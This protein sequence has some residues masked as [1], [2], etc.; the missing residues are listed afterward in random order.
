MQC[1]QPW[2]STY[3]RSRKAKAVSQVGTQGRHRETAAEHAKHSGSVLVAEAVGTQGIQ[4]VSHS[5]LISSSCSPLAAQPRGS[6]SADG[7]SRSWHR[8]IWTANLW[9]MEAVEHTRQRQCLSR[10]GGGTHKAKAVAWLRT[11][12]RPR[13]PAAAA[14]GHAARPS[15]FCRPSPRQRPPP[16]PSPPLPPPPRPA[17]PPPSPQP[18]SSRCDQP[19]WY[20][21]AAI[22]NR[23]TTRA[24]DSAFENDAPGCVSQVAPSLDHAEP[25]LLGLQSRLP[26]SDP[27]D[28]DRS[29]S[30]YRRL[31]VPSVPSVAFSIYPAWCQAG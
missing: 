30:A 7:P 14:P 9:T 21:C 22:E 8:S 31:P 15:T 20:E 18:C 12:S 27:A 16:P 10:G 6:D 25:V 23:C 11:G 4:A 17:G 5:V 3:L 19:G 24:G 26:L 13:R 1:S 2:P 28:R 29:F